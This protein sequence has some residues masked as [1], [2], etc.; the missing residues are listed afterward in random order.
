MKLELEFFLIRTYC[1]KIPL[2]EETSI[3]L[4]KKFYDGSNFH[5][6]KWT[7]LAR[8]LTSIEKS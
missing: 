6:E 8:I 4:Q 7:G 2:H 5:N 3:N 1:L